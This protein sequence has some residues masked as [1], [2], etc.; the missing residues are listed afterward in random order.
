MGLKF[1]ASTLHATLR[2]APILLFVLVAKF[3]HFE[4]P[5][6]ELVNALQTVVGFSAMLKAALVTYGNPLALFASIFQLILDNV[7]GFS[8]WWFV[9]RISSN[10]TSIWLARCLL[11][12]CYYNL[13]LCCYSSS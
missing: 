3:V 5:V 13:V 6:V 7:M 8:A 10:E 12:V 9:L 1:W 11:F 2:I 4:V